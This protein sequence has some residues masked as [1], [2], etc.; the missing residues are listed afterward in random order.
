MIAP[1]AAGKRQP[2]PP[3]T[4]EQSDLAAAYAGFAR[5]VARKLAPRATGGVETPSGGWGV[6]AL[7]DELESAAGLGLVDAARSYDPSRGV[8][9][10][11]FARM[12]IHGA[13]RDACRSEGKR[14]PRAGFDGIEESEAFAMADPGLS[15]LEDD[16]DRRASDARFERLLEV[17]TPRE[18][19]VMR[20]YYGQGRRTR[21]IAEAL[22]MSQSRAS[23]V[24]MEALGKI[25][26]RLAVHTPTPDHATEPNP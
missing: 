10:A 18:R 8:K 25:R 22:E 20:A 14:R 19:I 23:A 24:H 3:L 16:E 17:L 5:H 21:E 7:A 11:T 4:A 13:I 15:A 1:T 2:K 26:D 9:F 12:R 6:T